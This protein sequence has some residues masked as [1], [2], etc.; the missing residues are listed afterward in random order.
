MPVVVAIIAL[1]FVGIVAALWLDGGPILAWALEHPISS[2]SGRRIVIGSVAIEWGLHSSRLIINDIQF[3]NASW[4]TNP[5]MF[6]AHRVE[7][8]FAPKSLIFQPVR[9]GLVEID[10]GK[11]WL[12]TSSTGAGNWQLSTAK[13][14]V[15]TH[16]G[17]F[18]EIAKFVTRES[19]FH[20]LNGESGAHDDIRIGQL[21]LD[22][23][24]LTAPVKLAGVGIFQGQSLRI[25]GA[26]GPL[27]QLRN[28]AKPYPVSLKGTYGEVE[29]VIDGTVAK[30]LETSGMDLR[31]SLSG[32]RLENFAEALGV[33][34]PPLPQFRGT[35]VLTGG[36]GRYAL[37]KLTLKLGASDLEGGIDVDA[38]GKIVYLRANFT[39]HFLDL[40]NFKGAYGGNPKGAAPKHPTGSAG[41]SEAIP[42][43]QIEVGRLPGLNADLTFY[44]TNVAH[45]AGTPLENVT[46]AL[47]LKNG[48]LWLQPLK[49]HVAQGDVALNANYRPTVGG[50]PQLK[51]DVDIRHVDLHQMLSSPDLPSMVRST[52][53]IA[54]G[55]L[56]IDSSGVSPREILARMNGQLTLMVQNGQMSDLLQQL[57]NLNVLRAIGVYIGGDKRVPINCAI[58]DFGVERGKA[59]THTF[60]IDT[61]QMRTTGQGTIDFA[62]DTLDLTLVPRNK[63]FTAVTLS[64]PIHLTGPIGKPNFSVESS[65]PNTRLGEAKTLAVVPPAALVTMIDTGLGQDNACSR[66]FHGQPVPAR[67]SPAPQP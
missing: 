23:P 39:S 67:Q 6:A 38:T 15:P 31:I 40:A 45:I 2:K 1:L 8:D 5:D 52:A 59:K 13:A 50:P 4:G 29:T 28:T 36:N 48:Q 53:G 61:N 30:P 32:K 43:T 57:V 12:E 35:A 60:V 51:G 55:R 9:L 10:N 42:N 3:G 11:L 33:P 37:D 64:S 14:A 21:A 62:N 17:R 34:L 63:K 25:G 20:W 22:E 26:L 46:L 41:S 16:R 66:A 27:A 54:A 19:E 65:F 24:Q 49:F 58:M 44:G 56:Q 47:H 7:V 18:P